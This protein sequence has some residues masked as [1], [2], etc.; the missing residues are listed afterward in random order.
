M[1][2]SQRVNQT[3]RTL[4]RVRRVVDV[5]VSHDGGTLALAV[6]PAHRQAG[7]SFESRVWRVPLTGDASQLTFGPGSDAMPRWSPND[8]RLAF[9]SDR[10]L[11]GRMSL[12]L[13]LPG[14]RPAP[15]GEISG[16]VEQAAWEPDGGSLLVLAVDEGGFGAATDGAVR[17]SWSDPPPDPFVDRGDQGWRR[18]LRVEADTGATSD[19]GPD[20]VTVWEFDVV[21]DRTVVALVSNDPSESGWYEARLVM[22]DLESRKLDDLWTPERQTQGPAVDPSGRRVA[23]IE[24]W[25][26]DR[27][28]VAGDIRILDFEKGDNTLLSPSLSDVSSV[29]WID[30]E[31]MWFAGW[32]E[33][34]SRFG[35]IGVDGDIQWDSKEDAVVGPSSFH[36]RIHPL[37]A[38]VGYVA[39]REAPREPGEVYLRPDGAEGAW[40]RITSFND[41]V[42]E[43]LPLYPEVR[44]VEWRGS[45]GMPIRGLVLVPEGE[46][47]YPTVVAIHGG[48]T[49]A[50]KYG[51]DP[52]YALPLVAAGFCVFLANY[53]GST[54]RG[55]EFTRLNVGD[56]AGAEFED[57]LLGVDHCISLG[58]AARDRLGVTGG[59]YGGYLTAWAVCTTDRFQAAVMVSGIVDMLS[60]HLT[61]NHAFSQYMFRGDHREPASLRLFMERSPVTYAAAASTPTLIIHGSEDQCTPVGQARE[62]HKAL[63]LNDVATELVVYPREGHGLRESE[64]AADAQRRTVAWFERY[65]EGDR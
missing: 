60:C 25:S 34:G 16:S 19:V 4:D 50:W 9:A 13:L 1:A 41:G 56:P 55:Q 45:G 57:I 52:G 18:L 2:D 51:F 48:P 37:P 20:G 39:V 62:L 3:L 33:M 28:L 26:S 35:V 49:W 38:G 29:G 64:H 10:L 47:P 7:S 15:L 24:G 54:G 53:R 8:Q 44:E 22:I 23:V 21:D 43:Q 31:T 17:L 63:L 32:N 14:G 6:Y 30:S 12:F 65:L 36:A 11:R 42:A 46:P 40:R 27:G 59:S 61:C 58:L 5:S